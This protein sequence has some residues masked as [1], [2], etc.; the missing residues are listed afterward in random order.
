MHPAGSSSYGH[1]LVPAGWGCG[2]RR[3]GPVR[4]AAL[5]ELDRTR[6][7]PGK[8]ILLS[9]YHDGRRIL[10]PG[11]AIGVCTGMIVIPVL[12]FTTAAGPGKDGDDG[13]DPAPSRELHAQTAGAV[14]PPQAVAAI[15]AAAPAVPVLASVPPPRP[16]AR[17]AKEAG[18]ATWY[19]T[20]DGTCAH[21]SLPMGTVVTVTNTGTGESTTCRVADRGPFLE[22]RVIDLDVATYAE[23]SDPSSGVLPVQLRW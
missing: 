4:V 9:R 17:P 10:S 16:T 11:R 5:V 3:T 6:I 19:D 21:V 15:P 2:P 1:C 23:L 14:A 20:Y 13:I 22:G 7:R 8:V 18:I 12:L